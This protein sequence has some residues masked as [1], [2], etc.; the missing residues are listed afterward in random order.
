MKIA[1]WTEKTPKIEWVK[2]AVNTCW[3]FDE[4]KEDIVYVLKSVDSDISDMPL[5]IEDT[6]TWAKN[7]A[8]NLKKD[9][10][11]AS[12]YIWIE[13]WTTDIMWKKYIWWIIYIENDEWEW[14]FGFSPM[15]EV[16]QLVEKKLYEDWLELGPVMSQLSWMTNIA[17]KN[18]SM[19]AWSDD[20][21]TRKDE[22]DVAFKAAIVPFFNKF[23]KL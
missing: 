19:W 20:I 22:F 18:W 15:I 12:Y 14:H 7:R 3:Y 23:Y 13:W 11:E 2:S 10:V 17:S 5:S 16:P 9:W 21:F 8:K 4:F 6:M 1:I